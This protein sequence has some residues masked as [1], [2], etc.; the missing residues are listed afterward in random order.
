MID[1]AG[2][3]EAIFAGGLGVDATFTP[4][5]GAGVSVRVIPDLG[6]AAPSFGRTQFVSD[7]AVVLMPVGAVAQVNEGDALRFGGVDYLVAGA[8]VRDGRR[9]YWKIE[10]TLA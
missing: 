5:G 4:N 6:D 1:F 2:D 7:T 9:L 8:P 3:T 10:L